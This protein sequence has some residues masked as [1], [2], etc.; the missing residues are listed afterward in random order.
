[1]YRLRGLNSSPQCNTRTARW[2]SYYLAFNLFRGS[3]WPPGWRCQWIAAVNSNAPLV[4]WRSCGNTLR[5][6][7][8]K[9]KRG[10]SQS[11]HISWSWDL[12][13]RY[14]NCKSRILMRE[15]ESGER[16]GGGK[17]T[18]AWMSCPSSAFSSVETCENNSHGQMSSPFTGTLPTVPD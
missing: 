10:G 18:P 4:R 6:E 8:K 3:N 15:K 14:H 17:K 12:Q 5:K 9:E 11:C 2:I 1:M 13:S 7:K 16:G